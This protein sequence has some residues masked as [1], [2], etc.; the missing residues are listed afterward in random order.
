MYSVLQEGQEQK[1]QQPKENQEL[2]ANLTQ[3][4]AV[5]LSVGGE[6]NSVM[7]VTN[8]DCLAIQHSFT[9]RPVIPLHPHQIPFSTARRYLENILCWCFLLEVLRD[10]HPLPS[11]HLPPRAGTA[12]LKPVLPGNLFPETSLLTNYKERGKKIS[13]TLCSL[14]FQWTCLKTSGSWSH[15]RTSPIRC[16]FLHT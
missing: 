14:W 7:V 15:K 16:R 3:L 12:P 8:R 9:Q 11:W 4:A 2:I 13:I 6:Q 1:K 5:D 10:C